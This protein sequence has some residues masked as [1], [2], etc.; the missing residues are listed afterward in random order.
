MPCVCTASMELGAAGQVTALAEGSDERPDDRLVDAQHGTNVGRSG[1]LVR[2]T[3][4]GIQQDQRDRRDQS[5]K[6][7]RRRP[8]RCQVEWTDSE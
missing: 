8:M 6:P 5:G 2:R 4:G 7:N 3:P 1:A